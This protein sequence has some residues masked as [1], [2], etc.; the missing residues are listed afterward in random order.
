M[1]KFIA[2]RTLRTSAPELLLQLLDM[3]TFCSM[4]NNGLM[5]NSR[6][7]FSGVATQLTVVVVCFLMAV[8]IFVYKNAGTV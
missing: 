8:Q 6:D 5:S 1:F 4:L 2:C 7:Y 3:F